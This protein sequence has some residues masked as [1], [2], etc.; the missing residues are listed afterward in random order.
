MVRIKQWIMVAAV[1]IMALPVVSRS[2][3]ESSAIAAQVSSDARAVQT[4]AGA[5]SSSAAAQQYADARA[6]HEEIR[7]LLEGAG[8]IHEDARAV[9]HGVDARA[10]QIGVDA[11]AVDQDATAV[12]FD[13]LM[14]D[15]G[16]LLQAETREVQ[17]A[18]LAYWV[19]TYGIN[20]PVD[21]DGK[22]P[23]CIAAQEGNASLISLL[24][25][26]G[27]M[28]DSLDV[29]QTT[30]L[31]YAVFHKQCNAAYILLQR[32]AQVNHANNEGITSLIY[33]ADNSDNAMVALLI[34]ARANVNCMAQGMVTP[35]LRAAKHE[36]LEI[37]IRLV[38]AGADYHKAQEKYIPHNMLPII[39][40]MI[41]T[42]KGFDYLRE[43]LKEYVYV[44][45]EHKLSS[46]CVDWACRLFKLGTVSDAE[47]IAR[48]AK[49]KQ[50]VETKGSMAAQERAIHQHILEYAAHTLAEAV[51]RGEKLQRAGMH[52]IKG[53]YAAESVREED[54]SGMA[55]P[56]CTFIN[57]KGRSW[58][59]MCGGTFLASVY[60]FGGGSGW[61]E[62]AP[63]RSYDQPD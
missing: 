24:L 25:D 52:D 3:D 39:K 37:L 16:H 8:A 32:G 35:L 61:D 57:K 55:C 43:V 2:A 21:K 44:S 5:G 17:E 53:T 41:G 34:L 14:I 4:Q 19:E 47:K 27:A 15:M 46:W 62:R 10:V 23:L 54:M 7:A 60:G 18:L 13:A 40:D 59:E 20:A 36:N 26:W 11:R 29:A 63:H 50:Y 31:M 28:V 56:Q 9:C 49:I 58:C 6:T 51:E 1:V 12:C 48:I 33:A 38:S 42:K 45:E 30:P 22:A